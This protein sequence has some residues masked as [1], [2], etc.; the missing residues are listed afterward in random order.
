MCILMMNGGE[1]WVDGAKAQKIV[2]DIQGSQNK[3]IVIGGELI[4]IS[5]IEGIHSEEY[6]KDLAHKNRGDWYCNYGYWH[7]KFEKCL[8]IS[9][10]PSITGDNKYLTS[11]PQLNG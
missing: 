9:D 2:F 7:K 3:F 11:N 1:V 6:M 4:N 8:H 5:N 10:N